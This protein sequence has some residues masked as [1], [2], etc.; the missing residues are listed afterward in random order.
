MSMRRLTPGLPF[1]LLSLLAVFL[2]GG[3]VSLP[4]QNTEQMK[5][6]V[7]GKYNTLLLIVNCPGDAATYGA[8]NDYGYYEATNWCGVDT[9]AGY[10]VYLSPNW[11]IWK[12]K[13]N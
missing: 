1:V 13:G 7:N 10:W 9:P 2:I 12:N 8:F 6:S 3:L 5:A 11:Y 4:A